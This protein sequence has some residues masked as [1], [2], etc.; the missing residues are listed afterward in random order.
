M[1]KES[2]DARLHDRLTILDQNHVWA[3]AR[4]TPMN[5][6]AVLQLEPDTLVDDT[7]RL[8]PEAI[9]NWIER[10]QTRATR[11]RFRAFSRTAGE[12][13]QSGAGGIVST[14]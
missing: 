10:R 14:V 3:E 7:G 5:I 2:D 8:K 4:D 1:N 11:L 12:P 9:R 6:I 13:S